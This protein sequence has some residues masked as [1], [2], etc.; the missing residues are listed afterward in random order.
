MNTCG[1]VGVMNTE[2]LARTTLVLDRETHEMLGELAARLGRSRSDLMREV[3]AEP[4]RFMHAQVAKLP[5]TGK[6]S[7]S[8]Y[9]SFTE[10]IQQDLVD[11]IE[12]VAAEA[13]ETIQ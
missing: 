9:A 13:G 4:I 8:D 10:S 3:V 1:T 7:E 6:L 5:A 2:K 12:R 11:F